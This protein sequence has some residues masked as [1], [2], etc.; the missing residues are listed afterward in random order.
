[1]AWVG[2]TSAVVLG[3]IAAA[4]SALYVALPADL[5]ASVPASRFLPAFAKD[6][7]LLNVVFW[8]QAA[9]GIL[10]LAVVPAVSQLVRG[11]GEGWIRWTSNLALV[12]FAASSIGYLLSIE[13][14]PRI[15]AAYAA[16]DPSTQAAL[17]ATWKSSID[18]FGVW[19]YG[20]V[21]AWVLAI[22]IVALQ[23]NRLPRNVNL[24]GLVAGIL[25]LLVPVGTILKVQ[26][27]LTVSAAAGVVFGL[28]WYVWIGL[29][30]RQ[31]G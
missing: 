7:T 22:S 3:V 16:G 10:G 11:A 26:A 27:L 9:V 1:M 21:G 29:R 18:L 13:R 14:L 30:L 4:S 19:G 12:G 17:A 31:T 28:I 25:Y 20:A 2:G 24:V 23:A 15:A 6:A 8:T 5:Q